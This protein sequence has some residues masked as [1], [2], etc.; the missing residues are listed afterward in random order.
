VRLPRLFLVVFSK[1]LLG[2]HPKVE[3][4]VDQDDMEV[5]LG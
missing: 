5:D 2:V 1:L 4:V 3:E